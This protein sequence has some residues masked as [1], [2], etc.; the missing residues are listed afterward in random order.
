MYVVCAMHMLMS[1][2]NATDSALARVKGN[3]CSLFSNINCHGCRGT[4]LER[5][6]TFRN[7]WE[8]GAELLNMFRCS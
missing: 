3:L 4:T 7:S 1:H 5:L 2:A 6:A 8:K